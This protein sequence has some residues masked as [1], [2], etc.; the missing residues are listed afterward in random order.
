MK[1]VNETII[2]CTETFWQQVIA[3]SRPVNVCDNLGLALNNCLDVNGPIQC[4]Y[5]NKFNK[6]ETNIQV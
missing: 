5:N 1:V 2:L 4:S 6:L 3:R